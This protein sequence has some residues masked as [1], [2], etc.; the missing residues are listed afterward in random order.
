MKCF[1]GKTMKVDGYKEYNDKIVYFWVCSCGNKKETT[2][3]K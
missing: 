3:D 1:C 2:E